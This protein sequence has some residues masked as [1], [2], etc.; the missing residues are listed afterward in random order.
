VLARGKPGCRVARRKVK[1]VFPLLCFFAG[2]FSFCT[3]GFAQPRDLVVTPLNSGIRLALAGHHPA[4]ASVQN[5]LGAVPAD[6]PF[7]QLALVLSRPPEVQRAFDQYL[8]DLQDPASANYHHWLTPVEVG[9]RFGASQND[10][11]AIQAWLQSQNLTVSSVANNRVV[12]RFSGS[13]SAIATAFGAEIHYFLVG[14]EQRVSITSEPQ[15]PAALGGIIKSVS[16]L[17]TPDVHPLSQAGLVQVTTRNLTG[18][19]AGGVSPDFTTSGGSHY[20][21]PA[22]FAT[23]YN[24]SVANITGAGQTIA[25]IGLSRVYDQDILNF[26]ALSGLAAKT[27]TVVIAKNGTD[28]GA[29]M[30]SPPSSGAASAAQTEATLDVTRVT[31]IAP[32]ANIDLVISANTGMVSGLDLAVED[33]VDANPS[34]ANIMSLSFGGCES[35][36]GQAGVNFF[37]TLFGAAAMEGISVFV[38]SGDSAAAG[39]DTHFA[40]PPATQIL[41]PNF[42]CSSSHATCVGGTE[43]ADFSSPGTYWSGSNSS[44]YGSALSYIPEGAWNEPLNSSN[45]PQVAGTGG[46]V[47]AFIPTPTWQVGTGVPGTAGRYTPDVS[48]SGSVHDG[49][50]ACMAAYGACGPQNGIFYFIYIAGTSAAVQDMAG[51][52]ALLNQKAGSAQGELNANLYRLAA[53]P[54][55][56]VFHDVT[57]ASSGVASCALTTPSMCNNSTPGPSGLA[58]GL[59][60]YAV[61]T[62]YDEA[63]GLGSINVANL[64]ANWTGSATTT[65]VTSS[66]NSIS[67]GT[68]VTLAAAVTTIG[69]TA[70][71]GTVIFYDGATQLGTGTLNGSG[72]AT[73]V[74]SSLTSLGQHAVTAFYHG[75]ATNGA[76]TSPALTETV[77]AATFTLALNSPTNQTISSGQSATYTLMVTPNGSYTSLVTFTCSIVP[78]SGTCMFSSPSVTPNANVATTMLT[79]SGAQASAPSFTFKDGGVRRAPPLYA[80]WILIELVSMLLLLPGSKS[81][82]VRLKRLSLPGALLATLIM[83]GCGAS[84]SM[85]DTPT[86]TPV[87]Q[88]YQ[89]TVTASAPA[90]TSGTSASQSQTQTVSLT[91]Q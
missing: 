35:Q 37:D 58:G 7:E 5:D 32:G 44:T 51:V 28:P 8:S 81:G 80:I 36:N 73:L 31:S 25:I 56:N 77:S 65:T 42:M 9:E 34:F 45:Q 86:N 24:A 46:G 55:N 89:I 33:V 48:F 72:S 64:L 70:P 76:S 11:N 53:T 17:S 3:T 85:T 20:L 87:S 79:I 23:I 60:G 59:S 6:L 75:D 27:E 74:T 15:I 40:A 91:V 62:G 16:G 52:A 69:P 67:S 2:T 26:E 49:Y 57:V 39:C 83:A 13:A 30:S 10:T 71:T 38:S 54:S 19:S 66:L 78:S 1:F 22:D 21:F 88:N 43:F 84:S 14:G 61:G 68:S 47:S 90:S 82:L 18:N 63:T 41:S 12:I 50:F 4:W 29:P